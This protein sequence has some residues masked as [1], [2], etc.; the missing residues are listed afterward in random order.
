MKIVSWNSA[1]NFREKY[2]AAQ[3]LGADICVIPEC[4][5]PQQLT[6]AGYRNFTAN[7]YWWGWNRN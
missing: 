4:E 2:L 5:D 6:D 3:A 1:C 7:G